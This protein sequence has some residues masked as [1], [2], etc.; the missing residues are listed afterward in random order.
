M[1]SI[2]IYL[3]MFLYAISSC[4]QQLYTVEIEPFQQVELINGAQGSSINVP[5]RLGTAM[6]GGAYDKEGL[7]K[8]L[9]FNG[10][11]L[12]I[13]TFD[14]ALNGQ[15]HVRLRRSDGRDFFDKFPLL[16]ARLIPVVQNNQ[17]AYSIAN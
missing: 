11:K 14:V 5:Q 8:Y 13:E 12:Q 2:I 10:S 15:I 4:A 9:I 1:K 16:N 17:S 7:G 3:L 6:L